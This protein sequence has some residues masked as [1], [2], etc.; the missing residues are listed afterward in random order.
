MG[1][2][3]FLAINLPKHIREKLYKLQAKWPDLP[4]KWTRE[5]NLHITLVFLGFVRDEELREICRKTEEIA[6]NY[7]GFEITFNKVSYGPVNDRQPRMVWAIGEKKPELSEL[8]KDLENALFERPKPANSNLEKYIKDKK[9]LAPVKFAF[10]PHITLARIN[11]IPF[12]SLGREARPEIDEEIDLSCEAES[13]DMME[14]ELK[15]GGPVYTIL[16]SLPLKI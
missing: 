3:I 10:S 4:A 7:S 16:E 1:R 5:D 11:L 14:S 13:I 8:Q 12:K 2:R 6:Q 9:L 15:R